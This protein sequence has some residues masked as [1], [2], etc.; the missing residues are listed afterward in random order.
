V[1]FAKGIWNL[2]VRFFFFFFFFSFCTQGKSS[3]LQSNTKA[4][5]AAV[6]DKNLHAVG[7]GKLQ[8]E[9]TEK[10]HGVTVF[11]TFSK[12]NCSFSTFSKNE[13]SFSQLLCHRRRPHFY[14]LFASH[15][16]NAGQW[17]DALSRKIFQFASA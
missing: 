3:G 2:T 14:R 12:T 1:T 4:R 10:R 9:G 11:S 6:H 16:C 7:P 5:S 15:M 13:G 8:T 17:Q